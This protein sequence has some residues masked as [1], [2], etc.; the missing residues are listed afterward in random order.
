[1]TRKLLAAITFACLSPTFGV[2]QQVESTLP[3]QLS[4]SDATTQGAAAPGSVSLEDLV[5]EALAKNP[6]IQS[7]LHGVEAQRRRV[8]QAKALPDPTVG[9]GWAGNIAPFTVQSGDPSS[10]RAVTAS[11][12]LPYPGKLRLRG[13]IASKEADAASSDVEAVRRRLTVDVKTAYFEYW[14][15]DKAIQTTLKDKDLLTKVSQIAEARYRVGK[16]IQQDVLR[17]QVEISLLLQS[18]TVLQQQRNTSQAQLNALLARG[19]EAPL[20]PA[21]NIERSPLNYSLD[22]LYRLARQN[23]PGL[24][25][26][27]QVIERNQLAVNLAQKDYYPDLSVAYMYQQ[28]PMLPDMHGMT[29]TINVPVFYK[30]K[31]RE[32]VRQAT[33]ERL[34]AESS[35]DNRK[36]ELSFEL[37][38]QYLSA[39]A[40]DELLRLFSEGVVPQS[41]LA[42]ESSMSA[43]QV[44]TV[45][46]LSVIGN[47]S[48]VLNYEIDYYRELANYQSSLARMESMV[49]V[50]LTSTVEQPGN[51][52][53]AGRE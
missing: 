33:E 5:R 16:G 28:R 12:Q 34:S 14:F 47:F 35:R 22:D 38:Q 51:E 21:K 36:N 50:D 46:F 53:S 7:A 13:E 25:R 48:T 30:S 2:A 11:Q 32:E 3:V 10:Y 41:S 52:H 6:A 20:A 9:T 42:L 44:G 26:E 37:K 19:P 49:G 29:F 40:S 4:P 8:P 24:H 43:Y 27:E 31:Q 23:D 15:Y 39:K 18:L 1:M 45:D 17:S